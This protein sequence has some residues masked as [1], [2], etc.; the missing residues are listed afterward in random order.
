MTIYTVGHSNQ[1]LDDLIELLGAHGVARVADVR[2]FPHSQRYPWFDRE[3]LERTLPGRGIEYRHIE[4]LGG[5]REGRPGSPNV[6]WGDV[7]FRAY[8]D[9]MES[10]GFR[11]ALARLLSWAGDT[12]TTIMCAE[13]D[14]HYCHRRVLSDALLH[15]GHEVRHIADAT[16]WETH[17]HPEFARVTETGIVYDGGYLPLR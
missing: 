8:A 13:R 15:A 6:G 2:R 11:E 7:A 9:Y 1:S 17:R 10:D 3:S 5:H 12:G 14:W 4:A 16:R